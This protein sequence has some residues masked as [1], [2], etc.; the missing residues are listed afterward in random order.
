MNSGD[1]LWGPAFGLLVSICVAQILFK[2]SGLVVYSAIAGAGLMG[3]YLIQQLI[4]QKMGK[5]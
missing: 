4:Q 5:K 2:D 1:K 3:G